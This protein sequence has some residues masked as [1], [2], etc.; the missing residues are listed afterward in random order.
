M[1]L[2]AYDQ[3]VE[4]SNM[5]LLVR[6]SPAE[7][8]DGVPMFKCGIGFDLAVKI[9]RSIGIVLNDLMYEVV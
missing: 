5:R 9:A 4:L 7:R 1:L 2:T 8:L 6:T 3:I